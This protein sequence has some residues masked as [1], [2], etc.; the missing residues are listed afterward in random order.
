VTKLDLGATSAVLETPGGRLS[1]SMVLLASNAWTGLIH[2]YFD[3]A[4]VGM[5]GQM[6]ATEPCPER[7]LPAPVYADFGFEYFR[8]LPTAASWPAEADAPPSTPSSR[9]PIARPTRCRGRSSR[10]STPAS[11]R[12]ASWR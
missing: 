10:S 5:R 6:F 3:G 8:Q 11:P 7:I 2:P 12:R 9:S 4:I 1:S